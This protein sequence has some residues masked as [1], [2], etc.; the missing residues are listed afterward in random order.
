M[1]GL[2]VKTENKACMRNV[3]IEVLRVVAMMLIIFQ[4]FIEYGGIKEGVI[5]GELMYP[6]LVY[7]YG[8]VQIAVNCYVMISGYFLVTSKFKFSKLI[9]LWIEVVFYSLFLYLLMAALGYY[10]FSIVTILSCFVPTLTGRYWFFTIYVGLYLLSPFLNVAINAMSK[11]QMFKLIVMLLALFSLWTTLPFFSGMNVNGGWS[12]A[13]FIV[14]YFV[15]A[16]LRLH[17]I[18]NYKI[19][20]KLLALILL[21]FIL[22][23]S[24]VIIDIFEKNGFPLFNGY[25]TMF[26]K[27]D[28]IFVVA[29]TICVFVI[30]IN[31]RINPKGFGNLILKIS[32]CTFGVYLI[33]HHAKVYP[34]MWSLIDG[35]RYLDDWFFPVYMTIVVLAIFSVCIAVDKARELLFRGLVKSSLLRHVSQFIEKS[36]LKCVGV[37]RLIAYKINQ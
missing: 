20:N 2:A 27:Y 10:D 28:S 24:K 1:S 26:Y 22:P 21:S 30:F 33:H 37:L 11:S 9:A 14:L 4:H 18:P 17:Y 8:I 13:W 3:S 36:A 7:L 15:A 29:L 34:V 16:Y 32:P 25:S 35:A 6:F 12:I 23:A 19:K 5:I 31:I